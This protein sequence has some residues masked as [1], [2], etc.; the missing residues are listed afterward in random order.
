MPHFPV[1]LFLRI[2]TLEQITAILSGVYSSPL[3]IQSQGWAVALSGSDMVGRAE[4]GSGKTIAFL[5]PAF[6][7]ILLQNHPRKTTALVL[8][9]TRELAQQIE[10]EA[11]R[12]SRSYGVGVACLF[13]GTGTRFQQIRSLS[14]GLNLIVATPGRLLDLADANYVD[15]SNVSYM[16]LDEADRLLDMGFEEDIRRIFSLISPIRQTLMW[17][18]TWPKGVDRLARD[19][20]SDYVKVNVGSDELAANP[21]VKQVIEV[22]SPVGKLSRLLEIL[23]ENDGAKILIF[24]GTKIGCE[25]VGKA[26]YNNGH[27]EVAL[28]HGDKT[29]PQRDIVVRDFKSYPL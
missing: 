18:A 9:P 21:N 7:H 28:L 25:H 13:G 11:R 29:Q 20:F 4:T 1:L 2:L 14:A 12:F 27:T 5:L 24:V 17:T 16:V 10:A 23:N 3:P 6:E 22:T 8:A 15:L 26:L 19:Y